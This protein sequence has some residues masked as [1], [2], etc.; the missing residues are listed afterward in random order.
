[1]ETKFHVHGTVITVMASIAESD[2]GRIRRRRIRLCNSTSY[3]L[4][5]CREYVTNSVAFASNYILHKS[6]L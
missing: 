6:S 3:R 5:R 4:A 2:E 1:M